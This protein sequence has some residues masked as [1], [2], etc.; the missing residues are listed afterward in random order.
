MH[1]IECG[2]LFDFR[3]RLRTLLIAVTATCLFLALCPLLITES[4]SI[5]FENAFLVFS[6][7]LTVW[8]GWLATRNAPRYLGMLVLCHLTIAMFLLIGPIVSYHINGRAW[9]DY[10]ISTWDPPPFHF[11]DGTIGIGDYDPKFT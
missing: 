11:S 7:G 9:Y 5:V 6:L 8:A 1:D 10:G 4:G 2:L 3:F